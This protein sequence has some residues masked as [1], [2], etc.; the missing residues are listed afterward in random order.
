MGLFYQ[1]E[2]TEIQYSENVGENVRSVCCR[3]CNKPMCYYTTPSESSHQSAVAMCQKGPGHFRPAGHFGELHIWV[4]NVFS[5]ISVKWTP[6]NFII[7]SP[8][9]LPPNKKHEGME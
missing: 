9:C 5:C 1:P 7:H 3:T 6:L 4:R 2:F 8:A